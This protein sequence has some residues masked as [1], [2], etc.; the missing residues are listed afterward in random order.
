MLEF[1]DVSKIYNKGTVYTEKTVLNKIN[2]TI[3]EGKVYGLVG[4]NGAGKTTLLKVLSNQIAKYD[5]TILWN[6][7]EVYENQRLVEEI[8]Y[9]SDDMIDNTTDKDRKLY[10]IFKT[11][12]DLYKKWDDEFLNYL[13]ET[14]KLDVQEKY[15]KLSKGNKT[16]VNL[17]LGLC[18][19]GDISLFDEPST[20]L[21]ANNRYKFYKILME[22]LE[23][24]PRT[25]IISTHLID[26][27]E[28]VLEEV[29]FIDKGNIIFKEEVDEIQS[30][31]WAFTGKPEELKS[32]ENKNIV[33]R[34][35]M[36]SMEIV[37]IFDHISSEERRDLQS[38]GVDIGS[39]SLQKLVVYMTEEMEK[40]E[41]E[42]ADI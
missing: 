15:S 38:R 12:K 27:V 6:G 3:E 41:S 18:T 21:D 22:D 20:G 1:K 4:R 25:V 34:D 32:L 24:H 37:G 42:S 16:L 29:I 23:E 9:V 40:N 2:M 26:E 13:V 5:G 35:S 33:Y 11:A 31:S 17:I 30:K 39:I 36:G 7:E 8:I 10:K 28:S 19:R 14:F